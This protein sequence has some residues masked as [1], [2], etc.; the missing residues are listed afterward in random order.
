MIARN[1]IISGQVQ[2]VG[3]RPFVYRLAHKL[4]LY[5]HVHNGAGRV[6]IHI[7][8]DAV[9]LDHFAHQL[10]AEAPPLARP[11]L[12][13]NEDT[14]IAGQ[15]DFRIE[16]SA[17][18]GAAEVHIP[19]DMFTCDDCLA[20]MNDVQERRARYPFINCT[21]CGPRY[22]LIRAMPYD[23][24][25]TALRDF[26]LCED[27]RCEYE[28]PFD[29][30]FHAQP[31]ACEQCGPTLEFVAGKERIAQNETALAACIAV[32]RDGKILAVKGVGGYHLM[33]DAQNIAA[34]KALRER[35][36]RP[37]KPLAVMFPLADKDGL[38]AV[39]QYCDLSDMEAT[40]IVDPA[41]PIV[42]VDKGS[43]NSLCDDLAPGLGELGVFLPYAPLHHLI[44]ADFGGPLVA[45]SGNISGEP[46]I[47]ENKMATTQLRPVAEAFLHHNRPIVRPADDSV[48][49][50]IAGAARTIRLGRGAAPLEMDLPGTLPEPVLAVG[51]HMKGAIALG[52]GNRAVLSPHIADLSSPRSIDV[53]AELADDLQILYGVQARKIIHDAHS[54]YAS[55]LWAKQQNL[56]LLPVQHHRAHASALAGEYPQIKSWLV[57]AW[58]GVGLGDDGTLWGGEGFVGAPGSWERAASWRTFRLIGAD[59]AGREPWR[60]A[61]ALCWQSERSWQSTAMDTKL[62]KAAWDKGLNVHTTSAVGRLFDA[63]SC[64]VTDLEKASF[65]GQGPMLLEALAQGPAKA[66]SLPLTLNDDGI[67]RS[68]WEPLIAIMQDN[69]VT[70]E[71]RAALL[72]ESLAQ[73]LVD[74]VLCVGKTHNFKAVGLTG[75]VFQNRVLA[76]CVFAKLSALHI[77]AYLPQKIPV[78]D[79]GL[80][81]GQIVESLGGNDEHI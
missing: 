28:D 72:H 61:A 68:N 54:G 48:V 29:R 66:I 6:F 24:P 51:G 23:R 22:T 13:C 21:Q 79:G 8:G 38:G 53:L 16:T 58:D 81:F 11:K 70:Q 43:R 3:Y 39:R 60:S 74:Q 17:L 73:A 56:P 42:L 40:A 25:N 37:D 76:E 78:N 33:C 75:G 36:H 62:A 71:N 63:A 2:G 55:T 35:K 1:I 41:R 65:E 77:P 46:V 50:V 14:E 5:G 80:A 32:L 69:S 45:T 10:I 47:I 59:R 9:Q 19:P 49:R 27:C 7:E 18:G 34:V 26:P 15:K 64:M 20:E 52:W 30:R 12:E 57:F 31:L 67:M 4:G 44:L